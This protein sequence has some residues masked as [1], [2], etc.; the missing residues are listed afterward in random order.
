MTLRKNENDEFMQWLSPSYWLVEAQLYSVRKQRGKDTLRWAR[1]MREFK[2]WRESDPSLG[3]RDRVLWIRGALGVGKSVM[4]GYFIDLLKCLHPNAIV[5]YFFCRSGE[6]G[7]MKARDIL[8]TLAFQCIQDNRSAQSLLKSLKAKDFRIDENLGVGFLFQR[9]IYEPL[10]QTQRYV[11][12]VLD[13]IDES[14]MTTKDSTERKRRPEMEV[15]IE[16]LATLPSARLMFVSRPIAD[17]A[18]IV[19]NSVTKSIAKQDNSED[20]DEYVKQTINGSERLQTHFRS[21][22]IDPFQYFRDK[23]DSIFLWTV[24]VLQQLEKAKSTSVFRKYLKGFSNASGDMELLYSSI[25]SKFDEEDRRWVREILRWVV[26]ATREFTINELKAVV[27]WSLQDNLPEFGTFLEI[28][29][30][31]LV[32]LLFQPVADRFPQFGHLK[33]RSENVRLIHETLRSYILDRSCARTD[34]FVDAGIMQENA[35]AI[36]L[37]ILSYGGPLHGFI[38]YAAQHWISHLRHVEMARSSHRA[39][40]RLFQFFQSPDGCRVWI[41]TFVKRFPD[42]GGRYPSLEMDQ[43]LQQIHQWLTD[44]GPSETADLCEDSISQ[45]EFFQSVTWRSQVL[46][47]PLVLGEY[48]GKGAAQLWLDDEVAKA[49][50]WNQIEIRSAILLSLRY[51]C[52]KSRGMASDAVTDFQ[53]FAVDRFASIMRWSGSKVCAINKKNL[54]LAFLEVRLW[55]CVISCL[56]EIPETDRDRDV[57]NCLVVAYWESGDYDGAVKAFNALISGEATNPEH[58]KSLG[59]AYQAKGDIQAAIDAFERS[60]SGDGDLH[61]RNALSPSLARPNGSTFVHLAEA[62]LTNGDWQGAINTYKRAVTAFPDR[63]WAWQGLVEAYTTKGDI[64]EAIRTY[65]KAVEE[66]NIKGW[67]YDNLWKADRARVDNQGGISMGTLIS[68]SR[69]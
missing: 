44:W 68:S 2:T 64:G 22:G 39:L 58:L 17:I 23:A 25:L 51:F 55:H 20:I 28:E 9:L 30:G 49:E 40:L 56:Q 41:Q 42:P 32:H 13:G 1:N 14:D 26:V 35:L 63:W 69:H 15:L 3:S 43:L 4:A 46:K 6:A 60:C 18:R 50:G 7:L 53:A 52:L 66:N 27:E 24:L 8:R 19:P 10:L 65:R 48:A 31:S 11:Y 5:A 61:V 47:T 38:H 45:A 62:Y 12:I 16:S 59:L 36:C 21:E 29:C 67:T 33:D 37:D 57:W 54:G 34:F